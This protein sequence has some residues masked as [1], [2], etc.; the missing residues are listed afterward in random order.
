MPKIGG[1]IAFIQIL[2]SF[3]QI[4][5]YGEYMMDMAKH[6]AAEKVP[7]NYSELLKKQTDNAKVI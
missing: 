4:S 2:S 7:E 5:S 1:I 3:C 6:L